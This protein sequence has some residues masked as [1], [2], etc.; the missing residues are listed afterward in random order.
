MGYLLSLMMGVTVA[1][2]VLL[3]WVADRWPKSLILA[4][5]ATSVCL[6][7]VFL[8]RGSWE[9]S[10]WAIILFLI[11][12]GAGDTAG[13]IT[14]ATLGDFYG[15]RR[16]ATLR[17][18]I[19]FSHSWALIVS[20]T[21]VGW[22]ADHTGCG[23]SDPVTEGGCSYSLPLWI[24]IIVLGLAALCY[25]SLRSPRRRLPGDGISGRPVASA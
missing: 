17:G 2:R 14:W 7:L 6:A 20:P 23:S 19:T 10:P 13:I 11:L 12:A 4:G 3:G 5:C 15:R 22:W 8:V 18:I 1:S 9:G 21:F 25:S 16:F 24:G